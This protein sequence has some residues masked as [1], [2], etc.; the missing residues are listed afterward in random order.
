MIILPAIDLLDQKVVRLYQ[1]DYDQQQVFGDDP[2]AFA[3]SFQDKGATHLHL[4]DLNGA[5]AGTKVHFDIVRQIVA[6]TDLF[7][8]LGGGIRSEQDIYEVLDIGVKRVILGT[9][10]Q[11]DPAFT[12]A[13]LKKYGNQIAVGVD[14]RAGMVAVEG[15][16]E[17]TTTRADD[18]CQQLREWG[19]STIIFT[20]IAKDGTGKGIDA[21]LYQQLNKLGLDIVAS[22]GVT[23]LADLEALA[24]VN[25][26]G[27]IVG[28]ALY[29]GQLALEDCLAVAKGG[30]S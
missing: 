3:K 22:G 30:A 24:E 19:C 29:S 7:V 28:K 2:V 11:K 5:K 10:A 15:W 13:M 8:E 27:A 21:K 23:T 6:A 18:F 9:I 14:A 1:G 26:Y 25:T 12:Q 20:D 16:L 17:T 4:V